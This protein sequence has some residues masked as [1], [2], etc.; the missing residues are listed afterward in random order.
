MSAAHFALATSKTGD[1]GNVRARV[2][3]FGVSDGNTVVIG[4]LQY[5]PP[6]RPF[7]EY[8][9]PFVGISTRDQA[10]YSPLYWSPVNGGYGVYFAGMQA[11]WSNSTSSV[12]ASAQI[13][14]GLYGEG[15]LNWGTVA[16]RQ[17]LDQRGLCHWRE[18]EL[19]YAGGQYGPTYYFTSAQVTLER[20]W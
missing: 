9:K 15:G 1:L 20:A 6:W 17:N 11:E 4:N 5:T 12:F 13:G 16:G 2:D 8:F 19:P 10:N 7:G 3:Y 14:N 18:T